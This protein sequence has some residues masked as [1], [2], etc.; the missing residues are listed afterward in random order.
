FDEAPTLLAPET[1]GDLLLIANDTAD[2]LAIEAVVREAKVQ[3]SPA[4][5]AIVESEP[6]AVQRCFEHLAPHLCGKWVWPHQTRELTVW[7]RRSL[8]PGIRFADP[9]TETM[10]QK[11]RRKLVCQTPSLTAMVEQL[12]IAASHDVTV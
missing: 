4:G 5:F 7:A 9:A 8:S 11:I 6:M 12:C 3:Q 10:A 2:A 1:A